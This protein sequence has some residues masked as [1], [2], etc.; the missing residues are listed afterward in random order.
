MGFRKPTS[1]PPAGSSGVVR[2]RPRVFAVLGLLLAL[3]VGSHFVWR[4]YAPT[5]ARHA[6]YQ[7]SV[8]DIRISPQPPWIR[9]DIKSEVLRDAGLVGHLSV[10]DDWD[11]L[12][13]RVR[14]AFEL[15]P[16]VASVERITKRLPSAL[17]VELHYRQPVAAVESS[18]PNGVTFLPIDF[19]GFRLPDA[20]LT[21]AERSYLPRISGVS[22]RP[23]VGES[24]EDPRVVGGARLA[25]A[26]ADVWQQLRL[27]EI[28]PGPKPQMQGETRI[29]TFEIITSGGTRIVWGATTGEELTLGES[30]FGLKRQ[31]LLDFASQHGLLDSIDGPKTV[32]VRSELVV[33]PREAK[34]KPDETDETTQRK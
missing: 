17:D 32:D 14:D 6:Q 5:V 3:G 18:E 9:S 21:D 22:G 29:Y 7:I 34:R 30:P 19:Q 2:I 1:S 33:T 28:I 16:W 15:H 11:V 10:L 23:L 27:V 12:A 20:D 31:R 13:K 24:W 26:L 25:A 8:D 4:H